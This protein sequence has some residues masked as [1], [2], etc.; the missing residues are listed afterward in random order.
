[1][2]LL[3]ADGSFMC[4]TGIWIVCVPPG[5]FLARQ[6][7]VG[8]GLLIIEVSRSNNDTPQSVGLLWTSDQLVQRPLPDNTKHSQQTYIHD[9]GWIRTHNPSRRAAAVLRPRPRGHWDRYRQVTNSPFCA[10]SVFMCFVWISEQTAIISLCS[11]YWLVF[12]TET[13]IVYCAVRTGSLSVIRVSFN[14]QMVTV[15]SLADRYRWLR[16]R[17][18][19]MAI[20]LMH[21]CW[22]RNELKEV[23]VKDRT[24]L[25]P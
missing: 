3:S 6:P 4:L 21:L 25:L 12:I 10:H 1:M 11:L 23:L 2:W 13:E 7:P 9:P 19:L 14:R 17:A 16:Y 22:K 15:R 20:L 18:C 24:V 8:Q 5:F